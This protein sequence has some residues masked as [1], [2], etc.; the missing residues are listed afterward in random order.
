MAIT[1]PMMEA[2]LRKRLK[3]SLLSVATNPWWEQDED[4]GWDVTVI[5]DG[6]KFTEEFGGSSDEVMAVRIAMS[7]WLEEAHN[8][9]SDAEFFTFD[10]FFDG[11]DEER[12]AA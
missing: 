11:E 6:T 10:I 4:R 9:D 3:G 2:T 1:E 5:V 7:D 8:H 12:Y